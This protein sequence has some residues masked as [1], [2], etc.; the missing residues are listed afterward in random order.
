LTTPVVIDASAGVELLLGTEVGKA[1]QARLPQPV[2]E[3]VPE[4]FYAE[5]AGVLRRA[6]L[7][8]RMSAARAA[9]ALDRL[10]SMPTRRVQVRSLVAEA[11]TLRHNVIVADALYVVLARHLAAPLATADLAL[12]N[13]PGLGVSVITP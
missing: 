12:A 5:V 10:L 4:I 8:G 13:A 7:S 9:V 3:W 6:E 11:W 2:V 1:L